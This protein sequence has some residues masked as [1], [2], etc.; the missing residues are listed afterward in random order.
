MNQRRLA[1]VLVLAASCLAC[2]SAP[3]EPERTTG[4]F[5][6][7]SAVDCPAGTRV[8]LGTDGNDTIVGTNGR[9][10]IVAG[11]GDDRIEAGDGDD[12]V[13]AGGGDDVILGG[14]GN[15]RIDGESGND[16]LFGQNGND[17]LSGG[18][19]DDILI[20]DNGN[21]SLSGGAG[22]DVLVGDNGNDSLDGG[23]GNDV[24]R[25]DNGSDALNGDDGD[26][27]IVRGG[28]GDVVSGGVG[29][30]RCTGNVD[31]EA[32]ELPAAAG[33]ANDA[34][35]A[36]GERCAAGVCIACLADAECENSNVCTTESCQPA[37]GC[38]VVAVANGTPCP[39]ATVCN[40]AE[41]CQS[42]SCAAGAP[43]ACDDGLFCNGA[44]SCDDTDGCQAGVPPEVPDDGVS[45]TLDQCNEDTDAVEHAPDDAAC[46]AG[47]ACSVTNGCENINECAT[48]A[49]NCS[50][51]ADCRDS[52]PGAICDH[53][54]CIAIPPFSCSCV[55]GYEG[56]G[57]TCTLECDTFPVATGVERCVRAREDLSVD[58][59]KALGES[60]Y[61]GKYLQADEAP[62][63]NYCGPTAI[64]NFLD[65]YGTDVDYA[66]IGAEMNTNLWDTGVVTAA[67][68]LAGPLAFCFDPVISCPIAIA[69][70]SGAAVRAGTLPG[71][72]R[73]AL[74]RRAP[75]GYTACLKAFDPSLEPVRESLAF[76]NPVIFLESKGAGNLHWAVA[77]GLY[78]TGFGS[79][80][81]RVANSTD[82]EWS[83]FVH[84][85]SLAPVGNGATRQ[86]LGSLFALHPYTMIRWIPSEQALE[87]DIC[88]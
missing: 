28:G 42:G 26:D 8:I 18:T 12:V 59:R 36:T 57:V 10:C 51:H 2:S 34:G 87:G 41:S 69:A 11:A 68:F 64:K 31:C 45:C 48:G 15:D 39:D 61:L 22:N 77:I 60:L 76:G 56:D 24:L 75:E 74:A 17:S 33:C 62:F 85:W 79:L 7:L 83:D 30:D 72:M 3:D 13:F 80:R 44:E 82:R 4:V 86:I 5:E 43:L 23:G 19:G 35:C 6:R 47:F 29:D 40:G 46:G 53:H 65:W 88:P 14:N 37:I 1:R 73:A 58:L 63:V 9:D 52:T 55:N 21:D 38:R 25:G 70:I 67:V 20:G 16:H 71:D 54:G 32:P 27:V 84:D 78:Y 66:Q 50:P 49:H 81:V